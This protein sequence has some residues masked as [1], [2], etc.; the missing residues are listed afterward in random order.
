M[1]RCRG[2]PKIEALNAD[3]LALKAHAPFTDQFADDC[4]RLA[5][6]GQRLAV[7]HPMLGF[8]LRLVTGPEAQNEAAAGQVGNGGGGH[9]DRRCG[10]DEHAADAGAEED[11]RGLYCAGRQ[12]SELIA[13]MTFG[14]PGRLIAEALGEDDKVDDLGRVG[15]RNGDADPAHALLS[16]LSDQGSTLRRWMPVRATGRP[17]ASGFPVAGRFQARRRY[18]RTARRSALRSAIAGARARAPMSW[19]HCRMPS[20]M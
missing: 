14:D 3:G 11:A 6:A 16:G 4:N 10:A 13:A 19:S 7:H 8:D 5:G 18:G 1:S 12:D 2:V 15:A 9:R 17:R 20:P